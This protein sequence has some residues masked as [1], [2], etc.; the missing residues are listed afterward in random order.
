MNKTYMAIL[1]KN[2]HTSE[3]NIYL[4]SCLHAYQKTDEK[5]LDQSKFNP[6]ADDTQM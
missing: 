3:K 4:T 1:R 6:F 5:I 2:A